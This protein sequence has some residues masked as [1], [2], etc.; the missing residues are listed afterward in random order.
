MILS[1]QEKND[2]RS[3]YESEEISNDVMIHLRRHYPLKEVQIGPHLIK[4]LYV[5][6]KMRPLINNKKSLT[7]RLYWEILDKFKGQTES[8]LRRTIK[9]YLTIIGG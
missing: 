1:E 4:Y 6:D 3:Q 9:R 8:I 2:I 7:N 5:D